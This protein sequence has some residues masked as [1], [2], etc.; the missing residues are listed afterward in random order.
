M[1]I[2]IVGKGP[3]F[4]DAPALS[5][6]YQ[7]WGLN[8]IRFYREELDLLFHMHDLN[9]ASSSQKLALVVAEQD[10]IPLCTLRKF[11]W[12]SNSFAYPL[13]EIIENHGYKYFADSICYMIA[14]AIYKGATEINLWGVGL[15]SNHKDVEERCCVEYWLGVLNGKGINLTIHGDSALLKVGAE[16]KLYGY[17]FNGEKEHFINNY[18]KKNAMTLKQFDEMQQNKGRV[19]L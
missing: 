12:L 9:V 19:L 2:H 3:G 10:K 8:D 5:E 15:F 14:Y 6:D 13:A 16:N 4:L 18:L 7:V 1:I 17:E 11:E